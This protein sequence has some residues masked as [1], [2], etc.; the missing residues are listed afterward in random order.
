MGR[1][2]KGHGDGAGQR[3]VLAVAVATGTNRKELVVMG[4]EAD[5][6]QRRIAVSRRT[7]LRAAGTGVGALALGA[8]LPALPTQ[9][10][11]F[12]KG[13]DVSWLPQMEASGYKFYNSGGAQQDV[14]AILKG[15]GINAIRLRTWVVPSSDPVNGH[16]SQAE[17]VAMAVRCKNAGLPVDIDFH[18]GDTWTDEG[19]QNPPASWASMS[20]SQMLDAMYHYVWNVM[21]NLRSNGVTPSW[22]QIGNETNLGICL[23]TGGLASNPGQMTGLLNAAYAMVKQIFPSTP[24]LIHLASPQKVSV[25]ENFLDTY[26]ARGGNWDITAFSSYGSGSAISGII[27]DMATFQARYGKPVM[28]VEFGGAENNPGQTQAN[29]EAYIKGV[30]GFGGLGVFYWEPEAYWPFTSYGMAA[31]NPATREPTAALN[32]FLNA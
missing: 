17:T 31:W 6:P 32:G 12:I 24:V 27:S 22:V 13:A 28:Q 20:Y 1:G 15:Y 11:A 10:A 3:S 2:M 19:H 23:P 9:A 5:G 30:K 16:C 14:L 18:F 21:D 8:A 29:L 4:N 7:V 26:K 25:I